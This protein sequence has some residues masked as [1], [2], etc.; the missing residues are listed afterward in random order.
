MVKVRL[1]FL[2]VFSFSFSFG[3]TIKGTVLEKN[4]NVPLSE[5]NIYL[6]KDKT[7]TITDEKGRFSFKIK[8]E[9]KE[10]DTIVFSHL[11]HKNRYFSISEIR[12]IGNIIYLESDIEAL[13]EVSISADK[14]LQSNIKFKELAPLEKAIH[15]FGAV[16]VNDKIYIVGGDISLIEDAH[17]KII[18]DDPSLTGGPGSNFKDFL[19]ELRSRRGISNKHYSGNMFVYHISSDAWEVSENKFRE[20]AYHNLNFYDNKIYVVGGKR[21]SQNRKYEYLDDKIEIFDI[22]KDTILVEDVNP[23]QAVNSFSCIY[24]D[25]LIILG[26]STKLKNGKTKVY[27]DKVR[28]VNLKTGLWYELDNMPEAKELNGVLVNDKL[29]VVE[30]GS[31]RNDNTSLESYDLLTGKWERE[32]D[33]FVTMDRPAITHNKGVVYFFEEGKIHTYDTITKT[34]NQYSIDL[35]LKASSLF[36][37]KDTLYILGGIVDDNR[38]QLPSSRLISIPLEEFEKTKINRFTTPEK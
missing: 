33:F 20:R 28:F 27:S 29:Y 35:F 24:K 3:Q 8:A 7:G 26:G 23:H 4:S 19:Q 11:G 9:V 25:R 12:K 31:G 10:G 5:V 38:I 21:F 30:T 22:E 6:K 16:L 17:L 37:Y 32:S 34:L 14:K 36:C 18:Q 13:H 2:I 1:F 15:S